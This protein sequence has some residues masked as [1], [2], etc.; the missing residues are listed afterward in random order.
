V[1]AGLTVWNF[2]FRLYAGIVKKEQA[3]EFLQALLVV[4][5]RLP[6]HRSR[7]VQD[8]VG[9]LKGW[10]HIEYL[11]AYAP[12]LN[13]VEYF[14]AFWNHHEMPIVCPKDL[15]DLSEGSRRALWSIRRRPRLITA[16]WKQAS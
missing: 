14:W 7:L 5:D 3:L 13:P 8:Y 11:P 15:L 10:I 16:F 1:V 9:S 6:A 12:E 4:W 2:Y